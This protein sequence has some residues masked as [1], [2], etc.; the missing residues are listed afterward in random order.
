MKRIILLAVIFTFISGS[1]LQ[2]VEVSLTLDEALAIALRDNRD[3]LLKVEDINNAKEAISEAKAGLMPTLNFTGS[4]TTTR[5]Y[6]DK[7]LTQKTTQTTLKQNLYKGGKTTNTIEQYKHKLDVSNALLEKAK[8]ELALSI[9]KAFYT[10]LLAKEYAELNEGI[11]DNIQKHLLYYKER[12][13]KGQ[14]SESDIIN[15]EMSLSNAQKALEESLNQVE[16]G[17]ALLCNLLYIENDARIN[18]DSHFGYEPKEVAYDE[19]FLTAMSVR[20][21]IKQYEAQANADKKAIEIAQAD[22]RPS[23]YASW[24]YYGRSHS[25][26]TATR[27]WNDYNVIGITFSWPIFD[28]WLTK[29]KVEQAIIDLKQTQLTKEKTFKDIALELKSSYLSLKDAITQIKSIE[30]ELRVYDDNLKGVNEK[31]KQ[32]IVSLLD[33]EDASLK[34]DISLFNKKQ[35]IF[36]YVIAKSSFDRAM[37]GQ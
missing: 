32:G 7:D 33:L 16:S 25:G 24:D 11:V 3:I 14:A 22:S 15:M 8:I 4:V 28:G 18:P 2:A 6:Y 5:G 27:N 10:L 34:Q 35:A 23:V 30:S 21:E 1:C 31:Y 20:P 26:T 13:Q 37:G 9:K 36:D 19:A 29:S 12:Y 17:Q